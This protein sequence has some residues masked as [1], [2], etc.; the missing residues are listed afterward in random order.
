[1]AQKIVILEPRANTKMY[2]FIEYLICF[3]Q[4]GV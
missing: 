3:T 4:G 2:I 1:M